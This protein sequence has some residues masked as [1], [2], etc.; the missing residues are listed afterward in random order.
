MSE[1][2][3][4]AAML[5]MATS[6]AELEVDRQETISDIQLCEAA[7]NLG[8]KEYSGGLVADR[9]DKNR[10]ILKVIETEQARRVTP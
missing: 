3:T 2:V 4:R 1:Q 5:V 9:L 8:I 7:L 10:R 6:D